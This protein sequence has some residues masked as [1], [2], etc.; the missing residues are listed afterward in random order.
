MPGQIVKI[1]ARFFVA[2]EGDSEQSFIAW[3]QTL[4]QKDLHIHLDA[5]VLGGGGFQSMLKKAIRMQKRGARIGGYK[6]RF[7]IVDGDRA[8]HGDWSIET[9]RRQ[10]AKHKIIVCVQNPNH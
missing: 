1:R 7:L 4:S 9:L 8:K 5:V 6:H 10:A 3:L 2:V